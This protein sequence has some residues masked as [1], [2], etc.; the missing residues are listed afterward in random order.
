[1]SMTISY[2]PELPVSAAR[3]EIV[4]ALNRHQVIVVAGET[5]SGKTTQLPKMLAE[6]LGVAD[7][8]PGERGMIAHTQPRRI[9]ARSV[10]ERL[11]EELGTTIGDDVGYQVR[12]TDESSKKTRIKLMTDGILLAEI[13]GDPQLSRY[14]GIIIDEAHERSLNIDVLLGHVARLLPQRPDLKVVITSAT[15]DPESFARHFAT[16][17]SA[18]ELVP[19]PII[20]VSG[21][22]Y[23]VEIRYRPVGEDP[24]DGA[25]E[26]DPASIP[27]D[28][29]MTSAV[30]DAVKE[31]AS[32]GPGDIL[33][34]FS[35]EREIRDAQQ[36]LNG[37]ISSTPRLRN[38]EVLPLFGRLSMA[39][40]H[41]IFAPGSKR[42]IVLATNV[43]ETSLTVPGIRY[44]VDT[45]LARISRYSTR[46]K[47]QRL[48]IER[49]SQ[50]SA[51]QRSGRSGRVA[52]GIAIRLYSEED[53]ESRP[54]F[55][56]PEILRTNLA[57]VILQMAAMKVI[58]T[59]DDIADF[60]FVQAP[61]ARAV[62]DGVTLL[63]ELGALTEPAQHNTGQQQQRQQQQ[64]KPRGRRGRRGRGPQQPRGPLTRIGRDLARLPV[65][66]RL[67][68]MILEAAKHS[69]ATEV[70]VIAAALSIQ[71]PRERPSEESGNRAKAAEL[72][73]RF[74][75]KKSDFTGLLNLWRYL[76]EQQRE[77]SSSAFRRMCRAEFINYLRV[78]EWQDLFE[79]LRKLVKPLRVS[80]P[81]RDVDPVN[82]HD[83]IHMALLSGLLSHIG[84]WDE[85]KR[86]Y[87]GARGTR[88][89]I[90]PG[91]ALAQRKP[92][93]A[94]AAELV[95]TS[96]LWART[97][98]EFNPDWVEKVAPHLIKV[99]HSEPHWSRKQ[100]AALIYEKVTLFGVTVVP[101][102][103]AQLSR[104]DRA[105]ARE[106]FIR[107]ALVEGDWDTHHAFFRRNLKRLR[108]VEEMQTRMRRHDL[109]ADDH[110]L[111][112][113]YD[114]RIPEHVTDQRALDRW[115]KGARGENPHLLDFDPEKLLQADG[116]ELDHDA[117]PQQWRVDDD[118]SLELR[119]AFD[120]TGAGRDGVY[121]RVPIV[122]L[123]QLSPEPFQWHVPGFRVELIT[124]LIR[125]L[126]K[127]VRKAFVPAPDVAQ[128]AA[129][130]LAEDFDPATDALLPSLELA[131]RR[132]RGEVIPPG[133]WDLERVPDYL[134]PTFQV[135]GAR[136]KILGDSKDLR[137]LQA[138]LAS[139][140][141]AAIASELGVSAEQLGEA[142]RRAGGKQAA[143]N[144]G[145][146]GGKSAPKPA[147]MPGP[148]ANAA[149]A[150]GA[151]TAS[152]V[153]EQRGLTE[154]PADLPEQ[155]F[156]H[157]VSA[158]VR[159]R[160]I[161]GY[162]G[163][164][165]LKNTA[166]ITIYRSV[167]E[168]TVGH[169]RGTIRLLALT[170]PSPQRYVMDHLTSREK[171]AFARTPHGNVDTFVKDAVYAAVDQLTPPQAPLDEAGF[172]ALFNH[173]RGELIE[174]TLGLIKSLE[175][176]LASS[177]RIQARLDA[178][179]SNALADT[180]S[181]IRSQLRGLL[182]P[183][184]VAAAG[185]HNVMHLPRYMEAI[186]KRLDK[187]EAGALTRDLEN[188]DIIQDLEDAYD[189]ALDAVPQGAA[190]SE[191]LLDIKWLLE[192]QRVSL[193]AQELGTARSVSPK[194]IRTA[195]REAQ[196]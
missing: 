8:E 167:A 104:L 58:Q 122:F 157:E 128:A 32:E 47:V 49:I 67:G 41:R 79:Q 113:F 109:L 103:R 101:R 188:T 123:N 71:D 88:F 14:S 23:P 74:A 30:V 153:W 55:T 68:R 17:D 131:L 126:P 99:S 92:E 110:A 182:Y 165:D 42:R 181:D 75:D 97:V 130:A 2:P 163:L 185:G 76:Q 40:Q 170:V 62:R 111:F 12:F 158:T 134:K 172:K 133:S 33:V 78:R 116:E 51:R 140:N 80:V 43:A 105:L 91:S 25:D 63:R 193:F 27:A 168:R 39:E 112:D 15:I 94:M 138:Q 195:L 86:E 186:E 3:D 190:P 174:T 164:T 171:I 189:D 69:A 9:A 160:D 147:P 184:F 132:L 1:M 191:K 87:A 83:A 144:S 118:L 183:G 18:G 96:R 177:N 44:V 64:G 65:D 180:V 121:V 54:E 142:K 148:K 141:R 106:L 31:L 90:F 176:T 162:P 24:N 115:W 84:S 4:D 149:T 154:W 73:A 150:S 192:E 135:I 52:D 129:D 46:T 93:F 136:G 11:A 13:A 48:P 179:T 117:Y 34:F 61:P 85:R 28:V 60:P 81:N 37:V 100:G 108:E 156:P 145:K 120:P 159:V 38:S 70:L 19:A 143:T 5:G 151:D 21:R 26:L 59:P 137:A 72:H 125:S 20:E 77:L 7:A 139:Q 98:A 66:V 161:T 107:H 53:F 124:A 166:G 127:Q 56:D 95:E 155:R 173:V 36:A 146:Q 169:R 102:R 178:I 45:G 187:V 196:H 35:G 10:A 82:K 119:Y 114:Q 89:S 57:S 29:D 50:A 16:K 152:S 6:V 175:K 22:T 194:R